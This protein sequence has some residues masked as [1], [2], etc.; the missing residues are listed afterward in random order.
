M[1]YNKRLA[2]FYTI[3]IPL[4]IVI[5]Y[6][7]F[8]TII[9]S[10]KSEKEFILSTFSLPTSLHFENYLIAWAGPRG[11][12]L[13]LY[14][15]NSIIVTGASL[16]LLLV[17]SALGGYGFARFNFKGNYILLSYILIGLA[18]PAHAMIIPLV[19]IYNFLKILNTYWSLILTFVGFNLPFGILMMR[20][21]FIS[22][23]KEIEEAALIDG[24]S[25]T[26]IFWKIVLPLTKPAITSLLVLT[27]LTVWNDFLFS[28]VFITD[29]NLWTLPRGIFAFI[30][31]EQE[32]PWT[33]LNAAFIISMIPTMIFYIFF[34]RELMKGTTAGA[35]KA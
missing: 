22:F 7:I 20:S 23:P 30:G 21:F 1:I 11:T 31:E 15:V 19:V 25:T 3:L 27:F 8:W 12:G 35:L 18:F 28:Y 29:R 34:Q 4:S 16:A 2:I 5:L 17:L 32:V 14:F 26:Q 6:P 13:F 9:N 33:V 10:L 24:C